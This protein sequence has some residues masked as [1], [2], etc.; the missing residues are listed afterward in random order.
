MEFWFVPNGIR[1]PNRIPVNVSE[2]LY[3]PEATYLERTD[4]VKTF[5]GPEPAIAQ[6]NNGY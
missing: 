5:G 1:I 3:C 4:P 6:R 2:W